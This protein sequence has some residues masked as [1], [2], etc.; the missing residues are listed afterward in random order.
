VTEETRTDEAP[1]LGTVLATSL[2]TGIVGGVL[3]TIRDGVRA[4]LAQ[5][6]EGP[7]QSAAWMLRFALDALFWYTLSACVLMVLCGGAIWLLTRVGHNFGGPRLVAACAGLLTFIGV[8]V[9][10]LFLH[11]LALG[12][13]RL[14]T[15][16]VWPVIEIALLAVLT[17]CGVGALLVQKCQRLPQPGRLLAWAMGSVTALFTLAFG[18]VWV[19]LGAAASSSTSKRLM[20]HALLLAVAVLLGRGLAMVVLSLVDKTQR[21]R[22]VRGVAFL[23]AGLLIGTSATLIVRS[24]ARR[25]SRER[26]SVADAP[27]KG[28]PNVLW[29]VMDTAR[30]DTLHCYGN[31]RETSPNLDQFASE[32]ALYEQTYST[33]PW[34][35]PAHA[36][37]FTGL[38]PSQHKVT[39]ENQLLSRKFTTAAELLRDHGYR[40]YC[41]SN[42]MHISKQVNLVQGFDTRLMYHCGRAHESE[43]LLGKIR[44]HMHLTDYGAKETN[45]AA[46]EWISESIDAEEPFF[47][48]LNYME[49]HSRYGCTSEWSRYVDK[50]VTLAQVEAIEH[51]HLL[52]AI[53]RAKTTPERFALIRKLYDGD[54]N[55]LDARIGEL[56]A[57]LDERGVLDDTLVII[58]ADHGDEFGEHMLLGHAY[59]IYNSN[60]HVPL[61]VR[62]PKRF[63]AGTRES[64]LTSVVDIF[65]TILDVTGIAWDGA[66]SLAGRSL[67]ADGGPRQVVSEKDMPMRWTRRD[68]MTS[69]HPRMPELYRRLKCIQDGEYKYIWGG[70]GQDELYH[71]AQDPTEQEN[72][73][74]DMP[75][76]AR[77]MRAQL[78]E[79]I[80]GLPPYPLRPKKAEEEGEGE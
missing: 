15:D 46:R 12:Q 4:L 13:S 43:L 78:A 32:G 24:R 62:Y 42:N 56:L 47:I 5:D 45:Y 28:R 26:G 71:I 2:A 54:V 17:A 31:P 20:G 51:S 69:G 3:F 33:A 41:Y 55:Y 30:A 53:D 1:S 37:M 67:L 60:L 58:S 38:L 16:E 35:L 66:A 77:E 25:K 73:I 39:A 72:L 40:T 76:K 70:D 29:I 57:Y 64:R 18:L 8:S 36:S 9:A 34:T 14:T 27:A 21:R 79:R 7:S 19:N 48:F 68:V 61:I 65:P 11:D 63:E 50:D 59:G 10:L 23:V 6:L 75:E 52:Y 44:E 22:A 49:I 80:G 74:Y